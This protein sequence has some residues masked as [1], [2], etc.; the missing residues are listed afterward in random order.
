MPISFLNPGLLL[1]AVAAALPV[2]LHFLSRRRAR[3]QAFSDLRFLEQAQSR[4]ARSLGVRRWL[5]LLLRVLAILLVVA[6][7]AGPRWGG[8]DGAGGPGGSYLLVLDASAS[9]GARRGAGTVLDASRRDAAELVRQ[10]PPGA[11][12]QAIVASGRAEPL[13]GDWLPAGEA[14][15]AALGEV[16]QGDGGLDLAAALRE[17]ARQAARAPG[18]PVNL[19]LLGDLQ[20]V[21]EAPEAAEAAAALARAR[22]TRVLL[23]EVAPDRGP[24][25]GVIDVQPPR[26][27]LR[28]GETASITAT[29][30]PAR[31]GQVFTLEIDGTVVAEAVA[32]GPAGRAAAVEFAI[33]VPGPGLHPGWVRTDSDLLA[34]DDRRP[35]VLAV[36]P[37]VDVLVVHGPDRAGDGPGGRGGWRYL[38]QALAPGGRAGPFAVT[39]RSSD[40]VAT[41]ALAGAGIVAL[42][43]PGPLGR[44]GL[45][46]LLARLRTGGGVL[47]AAGDPLVV[48]HLD[49]VLLPALGLPVPAPA[50]T[51]PGDGVHAGIVDASHPLLA[52]LDEPARRSLEDVLWRRWLAHPATGSRVVLELA[53]GQP[54]LL[55]RD[56]GPGRIAVL[57]THLGADAGDFARSPMAVPLLQRLGSWLAGGGAQDGAAGILAGQAPGVRPRPGTPPEALADAAALAAAGPAPGAISAVELQWRDGLP[58]LAAGPVE[59]AGFVAFMSGADTLG[60][61]SVGIPAEETLLPREG[62]DAWKRRLAAIG[63]PV[64]AEIAGD[65]P[66][67]LGAALAGRDLAPWAFLLAVAVLAA[68][69]ALG[70]GRTRPGS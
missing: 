47:L 2:V 67:S 32:A 69:L 3:R 65:G 53:G 23:R 27:A 37:R 46:A 59:R 42:V 54:L 39:S 31:A 17:A 57:A 20:Q 66:A 40:D 13:F 64:V 7:A 68:E 48:S 52:G 21:V 34:A 61:V 43:D 18:A 16:P 29:V 19:V 44:S 28:P 24:V 45:E 11:T 6:G 1:G 15:A 63:L 22:P 26:R 60:L 12:V 8:A 70:S 62:A 55:E 58:W 49:E 30:V 25:G 41:G 9:A 35:F 38:E 33:S 5:L 10:L 4:Q 14:V 51:A 50:V 56:A 36:P